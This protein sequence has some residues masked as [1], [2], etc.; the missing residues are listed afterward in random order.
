MSTAQWKMESP[1][2]PIYLVASGTGLRGIYWDRQPV[3]VVKS[4]NTSEPEVQMLARAVGELDEYFRGERRE[5]TL[6]LEVEGT[7]FQKRVWEEL[8]R[9]PYGETV[10]YRDVA[11]R[12]R[13][14]KAFRAVGT[15]NGKNPISI[16][17]PCHR[18]IAADG[19]LGG[20]GGGLS[21]KTKLLAIERN[22][23]AKA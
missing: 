17:V 8:K 9:I 21:V 14:A 5:F 1:I 2:G 16:I 12:I 23:T 4:L 19:S 6:P 10:S 3:T 15:A 13:N 18:V 7:P 11:S 22:G 20:Y